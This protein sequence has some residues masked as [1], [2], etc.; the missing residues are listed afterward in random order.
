MLVK[1]FTG[2]MHILPPSQQ[3]QSNE[4]DNSDNILYNIIIRLTQ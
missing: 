1:I 4:N 2:Q 3:C